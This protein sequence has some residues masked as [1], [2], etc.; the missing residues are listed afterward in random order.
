MF[1]PPKARG[2]HLI[3]ILRSVLGTAPHLPRLK[4]WK[5]TS[6]AA[7]WRAGGREGNDLVASRSFTCPEQVLT[8]SV[9]LSFCLCRW[10][11]P[12]HQHFKKVKIWPISKKR[13]KWRTSFI[14]ASNAALILTINFVSILGQGKLFVSASQESIQ[15][16]HPADVVLTSWWTDSAGS[17]KNCSLY[18]STPHRILTSYKI[19]VRCGKKDQSLWPCSSLKS[20][21]SIKKMIP[22][23]VSYFAFSHCQN[24][25][26]EIFH[27]KIIHY[28]T[29]DRGELFVRLLQCSSAS[30]NFVASHLGL[31]DRYARSP[32]GRPTW[33]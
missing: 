6:A 30:G 5:L 1:F 33:S 28:I 20:V 31:Q 9:L 3:S 11:I 17:H 25:H 24:A 29:V 26:L 2:Q 22:V 23:A 32:W 8:R 19:Q 27:D 14:I 13:N 21:K 12:C 15:F 7:Q 16:V 18:L 10:L 4:I